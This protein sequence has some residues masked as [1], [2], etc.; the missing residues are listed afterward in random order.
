MKAIVPSILLIGMII[1]HFF[2][3]YNPPL[4]SPMVISPI[5][6]P[7]IFNN[8]Q[9]GQTKVYTPQTSSPEASGFS[10]QFV[11]DTINKI[12]GIKNKEILAINQIKG[13]YVDSLDYVK[14]ER[15]EQNRVIKYY[16]SKNA[17]GRVIGSGKTVDG[18]T[19]VITGDLDLISAVRKAPNKK[20]R[21]SLVFYDPD[22]RFTVN[23]SKEFTYAIPEKTVTKRWTFGISVGAGVVV[24]NFDTKKTTFGGYIGGS[25]NYNF[26]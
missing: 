18:N 20:S 26:K 21:D 10:E 13:K 23:Q 1:F 3:T 25:V 19:M 22:Q 24:P 14:E 5:T 7:V 12:M 11:N 9:K 6:K 2:W 16:E 15:D 4:E 8:G 17:N